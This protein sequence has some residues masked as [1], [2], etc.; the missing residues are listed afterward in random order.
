MGFSKLVIKKDEQKAAAPDIMSKP[1]TQPG[2]EKAPKDFG[3]E[4]G[5]MVCD[6]SRFW[7]LRLS[8]LSMARVLGNCKIPIRGRRF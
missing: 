5:A 3:L 4:A 8:T 2:V 1:L 6:S 7:L